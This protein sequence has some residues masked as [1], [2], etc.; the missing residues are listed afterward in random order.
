MHDSEICTPLPF[1][2]ESLEIALYLIWTEIQ[3]DL[4]NFTQSKRMPILSMH[5]E[6]SPN[7]FGRWRP[8]TIW[9][10]I[11]NFDKLNGI[12]YNASNFNSKTASNFNSQVQSHLRYSD[13][14]NN[15]FDVEKWRKEKKTYSRINNN[16]KDRIITVV[17]LEKNE[18]ARNHICWWNMMKPWNVQY[19]QMSRYELKQQPLDQWNDCCSFR[20]VNLQFELLFSVL[21][22]N[23]WLLTA[24]FNTLK[25]NT[26]WLTISNRIQQIIGKQTKM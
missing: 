23:C 17:V 1:S 18:F 22:Q 16:F 6:P 3:F 14:S 12:A 5:F 4:F 25:Q 11:W 8:P 26:N 10:F 24:V 2:L 7:H 15:P 21:R 13:I 19:K 9:F 20:L